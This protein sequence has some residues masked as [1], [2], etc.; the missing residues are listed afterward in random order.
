MKHNQ[1]KMRA[2]ALVLVLVMLVSSVLVMPTAAIDIEEQPLPDFLWEL[3]FNKMTDAFDNRGSTD[4]TLEGKNVKLLDAHGKKA[5]GVVNGSCQYFINDINNLLNKYETFSMEADMYFEAYPT[6]EAGGKNSHEYPLSFMTWITS[7][8]TGAPT[9]RS[10]R[11]DDEGYLCTGTNPNENP[12][13]RTSAKLPLGEWFNIRFLVSPL[14]GFCEVYINGQLLMS[15]KIGSPKTLAKSQVRFFDARYTYTAYF[16]NISVYTDSNYRIGLVKEDAADFA[17]YQTTKVENNS[18][19]IRLISG[20]NIA[21]I[22]TYNSAGFMVTT[23]MEENGK[24]VA[25]EKKH[26]DINVYESL[27]ADGKKVTAESLG[28]KYLAAVPIKGIPTDKGHIEIVV[29]PYVKKGGVR[30]YGDAIILSYSGEVK[31]GYPVLYM[32]DNSVEY[33]AYP[34]DDTFVRVGTDENFGDNTSLVIKQSGQRNSYTREVYIKFSFSDVAVSR[35]LSS[36]RIYLE[37]YSKSHRALSAEET[38]EG[39]ILA[40]ICGVDTN[41]TESELNGRNCDQLA[42]EIDYIGDVRYVKNEYTQVDVTDYVLEHAK[43]GAV[44]FKIANVE[45]E[46]GG[47]GTICSSEA[48]SGSPRLVVYPISYNHQVNLS[49]LQ[50]IGYEPWGYAE[51]L[52]DEWFRTGYDSLYSHEPFANKIEN[53]KVNNGTPTGAYKIKLDWKSNSPANKWNERVYSRSMETLEGFNPGAASQYDEFGGITNSGIKGQATGFFHTETH[54]VRTYIIDPIGNPFFA[55]GINTIQ[56]GKTQNQRDAAVEKYGSEEKFYTEVTDELRAMGINTYWGGDEQFFAQNKLASAIGLGVINGYMGGSSLN[57]SISTGGS[58]E[59]MHNNTMN[60]FDPDYLTYATTKVAKALEG[61]KNDNPYIL[62]LYSDNE[63][64]A[65]SNML[66]CYLTIDPTEPVN[67]F[68]YATA[69]TWLI[70]HTGNPNASVN[71]ITDEMSEEFKAFVYDRYFKGVT[72]AIKAAGFDNYMYLGNRVHSENKSSEGYLRAAS[73]YVDV[74]TCNLYGGN[75]VQSII[76]NIEA[77]YKYCGKPFIVT[78]FFAKAEDAVDMNG[79]SLGNQTNAGMIVKTQADRAAYY[80]HYV[81][82]LLESQTCVGWTWY[83]FRDNDQ[84]IYQDE[85]GNLYRAYDYKNGEISGYVNVKTGTIVEDGPAFAPSL[86]EFYKGEGDT[87]N[88]GS[89]K[90][91]YDNKM[92]VYKELTGAVKKTTDNIFNLIRYFDDLHK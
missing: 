33:T 1:L 41:W 6:G 58:A 27:L 86:K 48:T 68:S 43:G 7:G 83:R 31:D 8:E 84:T 92:N 29:R 56:L 54:G 64:P 81:M 73:K 61:Y 14:T 50:N 5:L 60:V 82:L 59:F 11:I 80:E 3:D 26:Y 38:A 62:G 77:M 72:D 85:G 17:G 25:T 21:D 34:S 53:W 44:A 10:I 23:I 42:K 19:D 39:G 15:H 45:T 70:K 76:D 24:S 18:F 75:N 32:L 2:L 52:V 22:T 78:E 79:Y 13:Q 57:L 36:S 55:A 4:Y 89:N 47:E 66:Y 63:I 91:F 88:L 69:W 87:S 30:A 16:S 28:S 12:E 67:A 90:G 40:D 20:T 74:L 71:D 51:Q 65:Q 35:L 37:F 46:T 9:Y 49:K